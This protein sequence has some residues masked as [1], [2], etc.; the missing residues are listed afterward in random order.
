M[1]LR[2]FGIRPPRVGACVGGQT[3]FPTMIADDPQ[4]K[5]LTGSCSHSENGLT[6]FADA[7]VLAS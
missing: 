4:A 2:G 3:L 1:S 6:P 5:L 7:S